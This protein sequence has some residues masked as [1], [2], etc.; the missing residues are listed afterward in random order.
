FKVLFWAI[1]V[2]G[3][4]FGVIVADNALNS[5]SGLEIIAVIAAIVA[6]I[7]ALVTTI[8]L[9]IVLAPIIY[10]LQLPV[11]K[12]KGRYW[13]IN[14]PETPVIAYTKT[15]FKV[16]FSQTRPSGWRYPIPTY[17]AHSTPSLTLPPPR[18][19]SSPFPNHASAKR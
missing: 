15:N 1:G 17:P 6:F 2:I 7:A 9:S 18:T 11:K 13:N 14:Q 5:S 10:L 3:T 19:K 4:L 8:V 12:L 16:L